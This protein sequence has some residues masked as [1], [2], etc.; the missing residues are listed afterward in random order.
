MKFV[1]KL[2]KRSNEKE[3]NAPVSSGDNSATDSQ[4]T[5]AYKNDATTDGSAISSGD[6]G[7]VTGDR[8]AASSSDGS[9]DGGKALSVS[10][11][12]DEKQKELM[13]K[14]K[15]ATKQAMLTNV[16]KNV[17]SATQDMENAL[18]D[19]RNQGIDVP[20][21]MAS[22]VAEVFR[23]KALI[24]FIMA[25][26]QTKTLNVAFSAG[27][28]HNAVS[29]LM[30]AVRWNVKAEKKEEAVKDAKKAREAADA[31]EMLKKKYPAK[32]KSVDYFA[33]L[34]ATEVKN[35]E[36]LAGI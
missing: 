14:V 5:S 19:A 2:C 27:L 7:E 21:D 32:A 29:P 4:T 18:L 31:V 3:R 36:T 11:S 28:Y 35:A 12:L 9:K 10:V 20:R 15:V 22:D 25:E 26:E 16:W 23:K 1:Y 33:R 24:L 30:Q 13:T 6:D 8:A 34:M 17:F